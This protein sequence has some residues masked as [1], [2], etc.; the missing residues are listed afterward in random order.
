[1]SAPFFDSKSVSAAAL[2]S[3]MVTQSLMLALVQKGILTKPDANEVFENSLQ[4]LERLR[5][6]NPPDVEL[7][8]ALVDAMAHFVATGR[9]PPNTTP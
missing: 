1:M 8:R 5:I 3:M 2:A 7:A 9:Q 4:A 6:G